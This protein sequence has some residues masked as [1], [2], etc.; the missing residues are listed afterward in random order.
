MTDFQYFNWLQNRQ[1]LTASTG[2]TSLLPNRYTDVCKWPINICILSEYSNTR[3][4]TQ[5]LGKVEH[6]HTFNSLYTSVLAPRQKLVTQKLNCY[7]FYVIDRVVHEQFHISIF[8]GPWQLALWVCILVYCWRP[9]GYIG[10]WPSHWQPYQIS[11]FYSL[12]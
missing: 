5:D 2:Q 10:G 6:S 11:F 3:Q 12:Y 7:L 4:K 1:N 9:Y 8:I